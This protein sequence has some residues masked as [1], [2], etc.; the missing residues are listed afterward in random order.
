LH[1]STHSG[2]TWRSAGYGKTG[3]LPQ[4]RVKG[5]ASPDILAML[6]LR[7]ARGSG[8]ALDTLPPRSPRGRVAG[9][10]LQSFANSSAARIDRLMDSQADRYAV[11]C[12]D[13]ERRLTMIDRQ[14]RDALKMIGA[15]A[16]L[17]A[18]VP[19]ALAVETAPTPLPPSITDDLSA[20]LDE[21]QARIEH[22]RRFIENIRNVERD[23]GLSAHN[24]NW[25][26]YLNAFDLKTVS[27]NI[28]QLGCEA[29]NHAHRLHVHVWQLEEARQLS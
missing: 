14:R 9:L 4:R 11:P 8:I 17:P 20:H 19:A 13:E 7:V 21:L 16:I 15:A 12:A 5:S 3:A 23:A 29:R 27:M 6:P 18:T 22:A 25:M 10:S 26:I 1:P 24:R 2:L 28:H